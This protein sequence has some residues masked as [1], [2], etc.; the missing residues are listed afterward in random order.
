MKPLRW[1]IPFATAPPAALPLVMG[2]LNVTPDSFS[3]GGRYAAPKAALHRA[4]ELVN[5]GADLLDLGGE[6]TRPGAE[7]VEA[8]VEIAR[9]IPIIQTLVRD[10]FPIPISIDTSKAEVA[11]AALQ[12]GACIVNDVTALR[13]D[14]RMRE[15]VRRFDA[16]LVLMHMHGTPRTMQDNPSYG[17]VVREVGDFLDERIGH[18]LAGGI[19]R[20]RIIADPGIGFGKNL[21]HNLALLARLDELS[22]RLGIPILIGPSRKRFI[23]E[24]LDGAEVQKRIEGTLAAVAIAAARGVEVVRVHDVRE[25]IRFLRVWRAIEKARAANPDE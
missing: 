5:D 12:A 2:I 23:G 6:S 9:T 25:T 14:D 21:N 10:E 4:W 15:L 1:K 24:L 22:A 17:D 11:E 7:S 8:E 3:D 16:G 20:E 13:G 18:A 19:A